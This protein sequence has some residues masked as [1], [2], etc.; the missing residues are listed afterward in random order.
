MSKK[1]QDVFGG[2][3]LIFRRFFNSIKK[4]Q[5]LLGGFV[6]IFSPFFNSVNKTQYF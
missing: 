3:S 2:F 6:P 1:T 4:N 5:D